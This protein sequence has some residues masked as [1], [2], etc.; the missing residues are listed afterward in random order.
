MESVTSVLAAERTGQV[1]RSAA[2][3]A[4]LLDHLRGGGA[5]KIWLTIANAL[6]ERGYRTDLVVCQAQG[7]LL[8]RLSPRLNLVELKPTIHRLAQAYAVRA[9]PGRLGSLLTYF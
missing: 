4:F 6:A 5:Q 3:I 1:H 2:P 8:A 7:P 9:D